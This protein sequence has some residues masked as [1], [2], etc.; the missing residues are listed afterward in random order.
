MDISRDRKR[1]MLWGA[2]VADA[3]SMG[4]H[5]LYDQDRIREVGGDRPEFRNPTRADYDGVPGYFAHPSRTA[6]HLSHYGEQM[7]VM[8]R[9]I[10]SNSGYHRTAYV[11]EFER[12]FGYGGTFVGYIDRATRDTLNAIG[13]IRIAAGK[14]ADFDQVWA[15]NTP[16]S[17][18]VQVPALSKIPPIVAAHLGEDSLMD[19]V[20]DAV[21]VTN[22]N[23]L[24]AKFGN[25]VAGLMI[26]AC[27]TGKTP[28]LQS[29]TNSADGIV[30]DAV[31]PVFQR[32]ADTTQV[33]TLDIGMPCNL[34]QAVPSIVHNLATSS[35]YADGVRKNV[36][37]GGD[38]CGRSI[39]LGAVLGAVHG[40]GGVTGIPTDWISSLNQ[41]SEI[42]GLIERVAL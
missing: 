28:D 18:D 1:N 27:E 36:L 16:G 39:V 14:D 4:F 8:M 3:A 19:M 37:A 22:N 41:H 12:H 6:G 9:A 13:R 32:L 25:Y 11:D 40:T 34:V 23:D 2:L 7:L 17:G 26:A 30:Q 5:W 42:N 20:E 24:S 31:S 21:R 38:N 15:E 10:A 33:V 35:S 29:F